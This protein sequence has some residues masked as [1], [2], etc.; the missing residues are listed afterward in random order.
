MNKLK[1][2]R[3]D[4]GIKV[5]KIAEKLGIS[6]EHYYNLEKGNTAFDLEKLNILSKIFEMDIVELSNLIKEESDGKGKFDK[7]RNWL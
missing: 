1:Q 5:K 3:K 7:F 6:R 4:S 2:V